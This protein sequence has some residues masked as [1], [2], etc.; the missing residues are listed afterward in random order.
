LALASDANDQDIE[1][2]HEEEEE[3]VEE[4]EEKAGLAN[5]MQKLLKKNV[6]QK[7]ILSKGKTDKQLAKAKA[8]KAAKEEED[9][10][11]E[12]EPEVKKIK[13]ADGRLIT[14]TESRRQFILKEEVGCLIMIPVMLE[15]KFLFCIKKRMWEDMA[16]KKPNV[17]EKDKERNLQKIATKYFYF[18]MCDECFLS[19]DYLQ[20]RCPVIQCC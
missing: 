7:K 16:R 11:N 5:V 9:E 15:Y 17:L 12:A 6:T 19:S 13:T 14:L 18:L 2:D 20:R 3:E 4:K 8:L 1:A 10:E